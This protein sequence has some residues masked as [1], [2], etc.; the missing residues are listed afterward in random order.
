MLEP[1]GLLLLMTGAVLPASASAQLLTIIG[2]K[3]A[4]QLQGILATD[5]QL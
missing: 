2:T 5:L 4:V 1:E 3:N